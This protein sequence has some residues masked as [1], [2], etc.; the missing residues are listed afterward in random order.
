MSRYM[1]DPIGAFVESFNNGRVNSEERLDRSLLNVAANLSERHYDVFLRKM[2]SSSSSVSRLAFEM[3]LASTECGPIFSKWLCENFPAM[4]HIFSSSL[5]AAVLD[6]LSASLPFLYPFERELS[7]KLGAYRARVE[8]APQMIQALLDYHPPPAPVSSPQE[9]QDDIFLVKIKQTQ[10][11]RKGAKARM[12]TSFDPKLKK[13]FETFGLQFPDSKEDASDYFMKIF[14][15]Q[16]EIL[17]FYLQILKEPTVEAAI[18]QSFVEVKISNDEQHHWIDSIAEKETLPEAEDTPNLPA[19]Y[20]MVQ[21]MKAALYFDSAEGFGEWRI[22]ISTRADRDLREARRKDAKFF[23]IIIKKIKE[24]SKG[25]FSDDN[26]KRLN[27]SYGEIPIYEAKMTRD[28]RLIYQI[29]CIPEYDD[30]IER[31]VIKIFGIYTH[32]QIDR[33]LWDSIGHQLAR[34]GKEYRQRCLFRNHPN[35]AGD[36][37]FSPAC[38]PPAEKAEEEESVVPQLPRESLEEM[39]SLLVLEKFVTFSQALLNSIIADLDVAHV[40]NVSPQE[41]EIIEYPYSCYVLGRSG[42]G[43]TTTM[44]FKMLGIERAYS[45]RKGTMAKPRQIFVTQSRVLANKVEEYFSKLLDSLSTADKTKEELAEMIKLKR[46]RHEEEGLIDIDDDHTWRADLPSKFSQLRDEHFPLFLTFDRLASLLEADIGGGVND[47]VAIATPPLIEDNSAL[48]KGSRLISYNTFL[49]SYWPHFAQSLTKGLDPA[50]VFSELMG[51]I[52]GSEESLSDERHYIDKETYENMSHRAQYAFASRRGIIYAIFLQYLK[53]KKS[54]G[55]YDAAD[56]THHVVRAFRASGIPGQKIDFLYVDEAQDNLLI[57]ALLLRSLV[58]NPDGLFWAGDTAQTIS[59]G[60]SFRFNDLKAF[61]FRLEERREGSLFSSGSSFAQEAPHM[62]HLA[63]NYRS[64]GG[65]VQCAHSVIELITEF[66]PHAIDVLSR[67]K[68]VVEGSKPVFFSGW[69]SETVRYEQFLFGE[70][71]NPIEFGAQQCILVRNESARQELRTQVG[72]IGLIMTLYESKGLE[73]DDVLLYKF[74]EDSTV[75]FSQWR[76]VLSLLEKINETGVSAPKFDDVRHAGVCSELKFLYVAITRARKNLWIVDCSVK[77]EPMREFWTARNEIQNCT[78]GTDVPRLAVSS[79][80]EEWEKSG[81]TLFTNKR[82]LQAM[83]CF[84]RAALPREVRVSHTYYLR[85]QARSVKATG[86]RQSISERQEAFL[87]AAE[88]FKECA[89]STINAKEKRAYLHNAGD[90]FE[91]AQEDFKAAEVYKQAGEFTTAAK[92]Y[93]KCAK[94]DEAVEIIT[95]NRQAV[96]SNV[97]Q[98]IVEIAKLFYFKNNELS[99]ASQLFDTIDDQLEYL[100]DFDLDVSRAALLENLGRFREAAEVHLDEGRTFDAIRLFL[101]DENEDSIL[102]GQDCIVRGLWE[103]ASFG[104]NLSERKEEVTRLLKLSSNRRSAD[105]ASKSTLADE[106]AMFQ[107]IRAGDLP[108]LCL[109]GR[110]FSGTSNAISATLCYD[111]YFKTI[112]IMYRMSQA[113]LSELLHDFYLYVRHLHRLGNLVNPCQDLD[114]CKLFCIQPST[115]GNFFVPCDTFLHQVLLERRALLISSNEQG[116]ILSEWEL[117]KRVKTILQNRLLTR[118]RRE[119]DEYRQAQAF[120]PC[121]FDII[122]GHCGRPDCSRRH[123]SPSSLNRDWYRL[124]VKIHLQQINIIQTFAVVPVNLA[125]DRMMHFKHWIGRLFN[126][127]HPSNYR[128]GSPADLD[129]SSIPEAP[130][131]SSILKRWHMDLLYDQTYAPRDNRLLTTV[132][133]ISRLSRLMGDRNPLPIIRSPLANVFKTGPD[134]WRKSGNTSVYIVPELVAALVSGRYNAVVGGVSFVR[135]VLEKAIPIDANAIFHL[136][137]VTCGLIVLIRRKLDLHNITMPRSWLDMLLRNI[138]LKANVSDIPMAL[139]IVFVASLGQLMLNLHNGQQQLCALLVE[140]KDL[141]TLSGHRPI[142]LSRICRAIALVGYNLNNDVLR[143]EIVKL[144]KALRPQGQPPYKQPHNLY[145]NYTSTREWSDVAKA[146]QRSTNDSSLDELI[147]LY[148]ISKTES[149]PPA[150]SVRRV[151]FKTSVDVHRLLDPLNPV[152]VSNLRADAPAFIPKPREPEAS[153]SVT[154]EEPEQEIEEPEADNTEVVNIS[155]PVEVAPVAEQ[156]ETK[157]PSEE[158]I[159]A[160]SCIQARYRK[161]LRSKRQTSR[162]ALETLRASC[163]EACLAESRKIEWPPRSHYLLLFLG[164]LPHVLTCLN[165]VH[166]WVM[167]T[168]QR[169]KKRFKTATHQELD[170]V[171]KR[172]TEQ[173]KM[174]NQIRDLRKALNPESQLHRKRDVE[175]LKRLVR[176]VETFISN[177]ASNV[178]RDVEEDMARGIK[179]IVTVRAAPKPK[180]KP[181]LRI[182]DDAAEYVEDEVEKR[183]IGDA[184][185]EESIMVPMRRSEKECRIVQ[186]TRVMDNMTG[187]GGQEV[188]QGDEGKEMVPRMRSR[189]WVSVPV[190]DQGEEET[191]GSEDG[192]SEDGRAW[193][194]I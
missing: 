68:G 183:S 62:F 29:D 121:P 23:K 47:K 151:M 96:D 43:K 61:M 184:I 128:L 46:R 90:C 148:D 83:H 4:P 124:Q 73:F 40:F 97:A 180:P 132:Y 108:K 174:I 158:L 48:G 137:D 58:R 129:F 56:R 81:R 168:K 44:L 140:N 27:G 118:V 169:N 111:H 13:A 67:E 166:T 25:H 64:H 185:A 155:A 163:F 116:I 190:A 139:I 17:K 154:G 194:S 159:R 150:R 141:F 59:V 93:R 37:V 74:F 157:P 80:P 160:A 8:H 165:A 122:I 9:M 85:E 136:I 89:V 15:G 65:I 162:T 57:D 99:K 182:D 117:K 88:A 153:T 26:Q 143:N 172:L 120:S 112:P 34:K 181:T 178:A 19:A 126:T 52:Q 179:G 92:L 145:R 69:D 77:G 134:Y 72:E 164:P 175:E 16:M 127:L 76:V 3:L 131:A 32:A 115:G 98:N 42:T 39:H 135:H 10:R 87:A 188:H 36:N 142:Y 176:A 171:N 170:D 94:F 14:A 123:L 95:Q 49:E 21:P 18:R 33:R 51:V 156:E 100:E 113:E 1:K 91:H 152:L 82:Y 161:I 106:L 70:S 7:L 167:E 20:P 63:V 104:V 101:M 189:P 5:V 2:L 173:K 187:N 149:H 75:D 12:T 114:F 54:S 24:L 45:L 66:W 105:A 130:I 71:G 38:F 31:Q 30:S 78:P 193:A 22:L 146:F 79:S 147:Q 50:L 55:E 11:Q 86:S 102:R 41:K 191:S 138:D 6:R 186:A 28:S 125:S 103:H 192:S 53:Q 144:M 119:N 35:S 107:A 84:E 177:A 109:L 60:S 110:K 133:Q